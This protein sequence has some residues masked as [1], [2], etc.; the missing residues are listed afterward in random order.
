MA[1]KDVPL[2][3][4]VKAVVLR[5]SEQGRQL[6]RVATS[7]SSVY[8]QERASDHLEFQG[9]V[10]AEVS[11]TLPPPAGAPARSS[12]QDGSYEVK[13]ESEAWAEGMR[14]DGE[15]DRCDKR[16]SRP[17]I[18][19]HLVMATY[20]PPTITCSDRWGTPTWCRSR[21][22]G[23]QPRTTPKGCTGRL[24]AMRGALGLSGRHHCGST[25]WSMPTE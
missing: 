6:G 17:Q 22:S 21:T 14:L 5:T 10:T 11:L 12:Q 16:L 3:R 1:T 23:L 9:R 15:A 13:S 19:G 24:T 7:G 2:P 20:Y 8:T 25:G 4:C 18:D